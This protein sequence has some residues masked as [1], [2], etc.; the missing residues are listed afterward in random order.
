[1]RVL[2]GRGST[3]L[4]IMSDPMRCKFSGFRC[5]VEMREFRGNIDELISITTIVLKG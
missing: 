1:M 5:H 2:D 4:R 3:W